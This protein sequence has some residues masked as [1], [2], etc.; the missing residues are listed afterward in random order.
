MLFICYNQK[1]NF[2]WYHLFIRAIHECM[3]EKNI[4]YKISDS[5][6]EASEEV[7]KDDI[8]FFISGV[9]N[10]TGKGTRAALT[11]M[12]NK[13]SK[14]IVYN[15]EDILNAKRCKDTITGCL[16]YKA[17]CVMDFS[18]KRLDSLVYTPH[19]IKVCPGYHPCFERKIEK[20]I[21]KYD[22]ICY[23]SL[24]ERRLQL[25]GKLK[26]AGLNV[27]FKNYANEQRQY[28]DVMQSKIVLDTYYH[29]VTGIDFF[30][31]N[32]LAA[33]KIFFIHETPVK[34]DTDD[35]FL[36]TVVNASY[37]ELPQRCIE[38]L[39]KSQEE[40]DAKALEVHKLFKQ[41]YNL[42]DQIPYDFFK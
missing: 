22:V 30:R 23:G 27:V 40:R 11:S 16:N 34:E 4:P 19:K 42:Q 15:T 26:E 41:K 18:R 20:K 21:K 13:N 25:C 6:I 37:E 38:W 12:K 29:G 31:C 33:N 10:F 5:I 3:D 9:T 14:I 35:D 36:N 7:Q 28:D 17:F 2:Q 8:V 39:S 1:Y 32:F 24:N